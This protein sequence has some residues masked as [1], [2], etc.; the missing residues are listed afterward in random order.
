MHQFPGKK[1]QC[2]PTMPLDKWNGIPRRLNVHI[3]YREKK[4][5]F[6][7]KKK[8]THVNFLVKNKNQLYL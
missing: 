1:K 7:L 3:N 8:L 6:N 4:I 2:P 5:F